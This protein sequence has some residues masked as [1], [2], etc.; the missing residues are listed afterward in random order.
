MKLVLCLTLAL[1]AASAFAGDIKNEQSIL[2]GSLIRAGVKNQAPLTRE[3]LVSLC[4]R[5]FSKAYFLYKNEPE[6]TVNCSGNRSITYKSQNWL[7]PAPILD[8]INRDLTSRS[9]HVFVHCNNG[10]HASGFV[11][12]VALRQFCGV[13]GAEAFQYWRAK[14]GSYGDSPPARGRIERDLRN[15]SPISGMTRASDCSIR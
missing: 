6:I 15:F 9:G 3:Q 8:A 13:S 4:E 11:A 1:S 5:G 12:A 7:Q 10:A 2:G 14:T